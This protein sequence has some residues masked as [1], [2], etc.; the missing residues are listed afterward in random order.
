MTMSMNAGPVPHPKKMFKVLCPVEKDGKTTHWIRCGT[1]FPN[2]DQSFNL[3]LDV[4]PK[5]GKLQMRELD[6]EDLRARDSNNPRRGG[7]QRALPDVAPAN[8]ES[9]PF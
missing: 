4:F 2:R 7:A 5:N 3:Y 6:E 9:L 1:G 8:D